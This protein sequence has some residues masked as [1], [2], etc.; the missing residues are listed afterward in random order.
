MS[1]A[2]GLAGTTHATF[3]VLQRFTEGNNPDVVFLA[4]D[5]TCELSSPLPLLVT[6]TVM[7]QSLRRHGCWRHHRNKRTYPH[8]A[9]ILSSGHSA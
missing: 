2:C 1:G 5:H 6:H 3:E 4:G 7:L 9:C 8:E